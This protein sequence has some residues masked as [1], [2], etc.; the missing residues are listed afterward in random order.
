MR[1][2]E[3]SLRTFLPGTELIDNTGGIQPLDS[4]PLKALAQSARTISA[5]HTAILQLA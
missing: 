2:R 1:A 5:C 3:R 4:L